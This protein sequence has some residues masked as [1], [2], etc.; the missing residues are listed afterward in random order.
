MTA[1]NILK[2]FFHRRNERNSALRAGQFDERPT[3][4]NPWMT[5]SA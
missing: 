1:A 3:S 5:F 2:F 4:F